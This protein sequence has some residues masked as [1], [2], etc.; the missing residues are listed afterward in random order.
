MNFV[1]HLRQRLLDT[2]EDKQFFTTEEIEDELWAGRILNAARVR[3]IIQFGAYRSAAQPYAVDSATGK[4]TIILKDLLDTQEEY[5]FSPAWPLHPHG[6]IVTVAEGELGEEVE[7]DSAYYEFDETRLVVTFDDPRL[8]A[9]PVVR[10]AG[11]LIDYDLVLYQLMCRL[12][13][14]VSTMQDSRG[15]EITNWI[16]RIN[17]ECDRLQ[18]PTLFRGG[19]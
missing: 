5:L 1:D 14:K 6:R 7:E 16:K 17:E 11:Y 13:T 3:E 19:R 10:I 2:D 8:E 15:Q 12:R 9:V 4:L 18:P